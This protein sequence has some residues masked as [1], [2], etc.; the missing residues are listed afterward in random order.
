MTND[1]WG[2]HLLLDI[3][4]CNLDKINNRDHIADFIK[5]LVERIDMTLAGEPQ[6]E[7]LLPGTHN[8][9]YSFV[10]MITTSSITGHL[11]SQSRTGYIDIFS[12]KPF[13]ITIA[14]TVVGEFFEP[15]RVR[16]NYITRHAD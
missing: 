4:G 2:Y 8:E 9:G 11:V 1:Y 13:D 5:T 16:V 15:Q 3:S 7:F 10:Q 14:Q 12:C 6:I